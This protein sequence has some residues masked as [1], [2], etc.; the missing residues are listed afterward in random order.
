VDELD[1]GREPRPMQRADEVGREHEAALEDGDDQ[2]I[3][4][5]RLGDGLGKLLVTSGDRLLVEEHADPAWKPHGEN[6]ISLTM[7]ATGVPSLAERSEPEPA[8]PRQGAKRAW[9]GSAPFRLAPMSSV[10]VR[11]SRCKAPSSPAPCTA[12]TSAGTFEF[13]SGR[14]FDLA[15]D[16]QN[17]LLIEALHL[18]PDPVERQSAQVHRRAGGRIQ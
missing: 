14:V 8:G 6:A 3:A 7:A 17:G 15:F 13:A 10:A 1:L 16:D 12:R 18:R 11:S 2:E 5:R 4:R 9:R